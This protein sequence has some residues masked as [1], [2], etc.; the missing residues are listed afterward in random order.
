[1]A[2]IERHPVPEKLLLQITTEAINA[3]ALG[4][5]DKITDVA[6]LETGAALIAKSWGLPQG[7]LEASLALIQKEKELVLSGSS[8]AALPDS[9]MLEPY[10]GPMIVELIWGLF[11][12]AVRLEDVKDR[13]AIHQ[14]ALLLADTLDLDEWLGRAGPDGKQN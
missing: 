6:P 9:E 4:T 7:D 1:M 2:K 14:L 12:T 3:L 11:E 13:A 10:D 8:E 5:P